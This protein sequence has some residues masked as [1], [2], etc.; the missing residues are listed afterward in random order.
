MHP[1]LE[2]ALASA[3][4]ENGHWGQVPTLAFLPLTVQL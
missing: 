4:P 2:E 3:E 1:T